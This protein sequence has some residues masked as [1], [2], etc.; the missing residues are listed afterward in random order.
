MKR[1]K[2][3]SPFFKALFTNPGVILKS[4][5][6]GMVPY[7]RKNFV[8]NKY[9]LK[10]GLPEVDI[11]E[12]FPGFNETIEP[13]SHL[14]GTSLPIDIAILK[15]LAKKFPDCEYLEIGS[16]RGESLANLSPVCKKCVS[17]SL[18]DEEMRKIGMS[19]AMIS[20]QR[21]YSK[22]LSNVVHIGANSMNYD[23]SQ[24]GKFDLIFV[25]GDHRFEGV[26]NDT[27]KV[28]KLLKDENS[29]IIWHDYTEQYEHINWEVFAGILEG[30]T[31]DQ[32]KHIYHISNS[33]CAIYTRQVVKIYKAQ[34]SSIPNKSFKVQISGNR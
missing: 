22:D 33:L 1:S 18:S 3:I 32:R 27:E 17:V 15:A 11:L 7:D 16:W 9:G 20:M 26:K 24:L 2:L 19:E 5:Y 31:E 21:F 13:F 34:E 12:L 6:H 30:C 4:L 29:I 25:D 14:Y 8:I 28:F 23:F 10:N